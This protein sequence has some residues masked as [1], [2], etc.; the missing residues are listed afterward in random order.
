MKSGWIHLLKVT[1]LIMYAI[2]TTDSESMLEGHEE[3]FDLITSQTESSPSK[4]P[5]Y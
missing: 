3:K 5:S 2:V 1:L 4:A